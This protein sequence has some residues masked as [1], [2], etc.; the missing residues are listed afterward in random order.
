M[1]VR[2]V[3]EWLKRESGGNVYSGLH[4]LEAYFVDPDGLDP[5]GGDGVAF[6]LRN[7]GM[8]A[9]NNESDIRAN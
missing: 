2:T 6:G 8:V 4:R 5:F 9:L 7:G 3:A 1:Q